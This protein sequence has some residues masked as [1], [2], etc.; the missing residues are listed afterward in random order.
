MLSPNAPWQEG[1]PHNSANK[2]QSIV[3]LTDGRQTVGAWGPGDTNSSSNGENNLEDMCEAIKAQDVLMITV[4][5]DLRDTATENR[6]RDCATS[7]SYFF[8]ADTNAELSSAFESIA[9]AFAK[10]LHLSK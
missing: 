10:D 1:S 4:A 8:D 5:F 2:I 9:L 7:P 6:L 3:L